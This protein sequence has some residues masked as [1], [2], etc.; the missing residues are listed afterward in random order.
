MTYN[1]LLDLYSKHDAREWNS[2]L[3]ACLKQRDINALMTIRRDIQVSM[4]E[5]SKKKLNTDKMCTFFLRLQNS[6]EI[7]I[8]KIYRLKEPNPCDNPLEAGSNLRHLD[9]KRLRDARLELLFRKGSY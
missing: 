5:L 6:I 8:K 1:L 7:T 2:L 3:T 9:K 4:S